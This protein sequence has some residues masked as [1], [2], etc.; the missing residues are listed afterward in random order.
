VATPFAVV[1]IG[2]PACCAVWG[3]HG[4][5]TGWPSGHP[6]RAARGHPGHRWPP[7]PPMATCRWPW[8]A[9]VLT[10]GGAAATRGGHRRVAAGGRGAGRPP[11]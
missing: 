2:R 8:L 9:T 3:V 11:M 4:G 1:A 5:C 7:R 6:G 10:A